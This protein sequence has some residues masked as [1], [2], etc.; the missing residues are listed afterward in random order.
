[1]AGSFRPE[2]HL[3]KCAAS[4][5]LQRVERRTVRPPGLGVNVHSITLRELLESR[6]VLVRDQVADR[7]AKIVQEA[8]TGVAVI[9][10]A[11]PENR[12]VRRQV[13]TA[14]RAKLLRKTRRPVDAV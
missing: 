14:A 11:A 4:Q 5:T 2:F 12:Q 3:W 6:V 13:I 8:K 9:D 10:N 1:M 7:L